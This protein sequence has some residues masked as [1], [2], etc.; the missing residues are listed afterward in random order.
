MRQHP[1]TNYTQGYGDYGFYLLPQL[2]HSICVTNNSVNQYKQGNRQLS[3]TTTMYSLFKHISRREQNIA[4]EY[5][6]H[7]IKAPNDCSMSKNTRS[8]EKHT[9]KST[10]NIQYPQATNANLMMVYAH[11]SITQPT[12]MPAMFSYTLVFIIVLFI[13]ILVL[14]S[15]PVTQVSTSNINQAMNLIS[16]SR[17]SQ[18]N[19]D[20]DQL[21]PAR[22]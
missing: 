18:I 2:S 16:R 9:D 20:Q 11:K 15:H 14:T 4:P 3:F 7:V 12:C 21:T 13:V 5:Q 17:N 6:L 8:Q 10:K 22:I 1:P 19:R